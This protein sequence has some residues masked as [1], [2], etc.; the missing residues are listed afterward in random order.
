MILDVTKDAVSTLS[1]S[2]DTPMLSL[3]RFIAPRYRMKV[4]AVNLHLDSA[5]GGSYL[6]SVKVVQE[7]RPSE[8]T[9]SLTPKHR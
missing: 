6:P 3:N 8:G 9:D 1:M 7:C 5:K 4:S 2:L